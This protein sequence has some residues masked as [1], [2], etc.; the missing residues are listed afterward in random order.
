MLE[1]IMMDR[2]EPPVTVG[3]GVAGARGEPAIQV[4]ESYASSIAF[5]FVIT[6]VPDVFVDNAVG[7]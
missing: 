7:V 2:G 4:R 3:G 5:N 6:R 1:R